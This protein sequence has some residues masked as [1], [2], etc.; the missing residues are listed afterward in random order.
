[1]SQKSTTHEASRVR[2]AAKTAFDVA[3]GGTALAADKAAETIGRVVEG[4]EDAFDA[5]RR[6]VRQAAAAATD[7]VRE[8]ISSDDKDVRAYENRSRDALYALAVER[9]IEGRSSMRK[10]EL[11]AA[12]REAS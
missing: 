1:M 5:G 6:T 11:I 10:P 12:L 3:V 8:V 7:T 4:A 9:G 2:R